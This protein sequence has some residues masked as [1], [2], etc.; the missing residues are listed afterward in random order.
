MKKV[1][2]PMVRREATRVPLRPNLSPKCPKRT[3][4]MGRATNATP[5]IAKEL[6]SALISVAWGK[7]SLGKT[8]TDAVA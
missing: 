6:R 5:K 7:N 4:P 2:R 1:A 8:S 3:E